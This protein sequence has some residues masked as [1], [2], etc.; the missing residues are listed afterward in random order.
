MAYQM[1]AWKAWYRGGRA[2]CSTGT[3]FAELPDDGALGF[4][5]LFDEISGP[6]GMH[7]KKQYSGGD[8][9]WLV[10]ILGKLTLCQ[11]SHDDQPEKRYPGAIIKRG[12]W[13]SD[14]EM[15]LVNAQMAQAMASWEG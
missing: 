4:V 10:D 6:S 11:G 1:I 14:Q 2:F 13:T 5:V 8:L 12:A 15:Q 9:Y 3:T 7:F